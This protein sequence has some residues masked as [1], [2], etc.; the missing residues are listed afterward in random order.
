MELHFDDP[1]ERYSRQILFSGIGR[2][3]QKKLAQ[4]RV[5]VVGVGALGTAVANHLARAGVGFI[6]LI[7]RDFVERSNLQR[8]ML[9]DEADAEGLLPKAIAAREKLTAINR[10]IT[11]EAVVDHL[12]A[13]NAEALLTDVELI[14]D[15]TDNFH[16]RYLINDVSVKYGIP[17][18]HGAVVRARGMH[19]FFHP[20]KTPCYRC[21]IP[22][23]PEG[24]ETC[25]TVGIIGPVVDVIASLEAAAA[26]KWLVGAEDKIPTALIDLDLWENAYASI[27]ISR[28]KNPNCPA[29]GM[30]RFEFLEERRGELT[31]SFL[32]GRNAVQVKAPGAIDFDAVRRRWTALGQLRETEHLLRLEYEGLVLTLFRDGRLIV[33]GTAD[34]HRAERIYAELVGR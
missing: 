9:F 34:V 14:L 12:S 22:E 13:E 32:C 3:G 15:G 16:V 30:R 26:L 2:E 31:A 7:D 18:V 25:D 23:P 8:Q 4:A 11:V 28:A 21:L 33:Q 10:T 6:R 29:C 27:D 20:P 1:W 5:A 24:G 19:A 17:W